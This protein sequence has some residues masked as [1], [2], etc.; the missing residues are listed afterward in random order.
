MTKLFRRICRLEMVA[1]HTGS[2]LFRLSLI[3]DKI[4]VYFFHMIGALSNYESNQTPWKKRHWD[5]IQNH[6]VGKQSASQ[7]AMTFVAIKTIFLIIV[8][9]YLF[10]PPSS[11]F[12]LEK[13]IISKG[14]RECPKIKEQIPFQPCRQNLLQFVSE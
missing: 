10:S 9:F 7:L 5:I 3:I 13:K 6:L 1:T 14:R 2:T 4:Q 8:F 12:L 11:T